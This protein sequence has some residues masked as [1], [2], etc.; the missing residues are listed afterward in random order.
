MSSSYSQL[1]D[2]PFNL[3]S[4]M[5]VPGSIKSE[6]NCMSCSMYFTYSVIVTK[7]ILNNQSL[8]ALS[9]ILL[10]YRSKLN[11]GENSFNLG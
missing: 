7:Y 2:Y 5:Y 8:M 1:S 6:G 10:F 4:I 9:I 11:S 3:N